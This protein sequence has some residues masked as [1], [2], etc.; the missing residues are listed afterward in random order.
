M[1][2]LHTDLEPQKDY[3]SGYP[4]E[5]RGMYYLARSLSAQLSL[6]TENTNYGGLEKCCSIWICRDNVPETEQ[7]S[8]SFYE[9][10]NTKNIGNCNVLKENFDLI[11]LVII[12]LGN[13]VYN[14]EK[15]SEGYR[16]LHFLNLI[17]YP[18]REDFI[19]S[20][21]DYIDFSGNEELWREKE[22]MFSLGQCIL[23]EG[24]EEGMK[25]WRFI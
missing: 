6:V 23:E 12:R 1:V 25:R 15:E 5:K 14:G 13:G 21:S 8:I 7:Y 9:M 20:M 4:I 3:R 17:M 11:K 18:H 10:V 16:L 2:N 19:E 22:N 24:R